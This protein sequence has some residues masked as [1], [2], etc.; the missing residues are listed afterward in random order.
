MR[1]VARQTVVRLKDI[2]AGEVGA[3]VSKTLSSIAGRLADG[4]QDWSSK[5]RSAAKSTNGFV[6][7]SPWQA[8]GAVAL[9]SVAAGILVSRSARRVRQ[10]A[11]R[12]ASRD[13]VS[14]ISGG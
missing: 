1:S 2:R 14:E 12:D 6:R 10:R 7:S 13:S 4:V 5:A 8:V 3:Q 11:V 9:V